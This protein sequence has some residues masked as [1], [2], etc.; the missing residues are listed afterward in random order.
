MQNDFEV[1]ES[2]KINRSFHL[3]KTLITS[4]HTNLLQ[5]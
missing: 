5:L 2:P 3:R 1:L 4:E